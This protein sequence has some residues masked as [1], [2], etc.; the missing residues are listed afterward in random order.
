MILFFSLGLSQ[1]SNSN[2]IFLVGL[3]IVELVFIGLQKILM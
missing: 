1:K 2:A 3:K